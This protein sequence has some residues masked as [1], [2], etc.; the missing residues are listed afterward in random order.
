MDV[1]DVEKMIAGLNNH[2]P[3]SRRSLLDYAESNDLTYRARSGETV[4]IDRSEI[5]YLL[6]ICTEIEKMQ[7]RLPIF[8]STDISGETP[9]WKADGKTEAKILAR[10]LGKTLIREDSIRIYHPDYQSL[11]KIIPNSVIIV[12]IP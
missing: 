8:I 12:Y 10:I 1:S 3:V 2:M 5:D 9:A 11:M 7:L 6:S 4:S